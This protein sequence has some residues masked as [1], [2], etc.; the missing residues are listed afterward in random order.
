[1]TDLS[2]GAPSPNEVVDAAI[3]AFARDGYAAVKV[4]ALAKQ[5]GMTKRMIHYHFG[6][7]RGLYMRALQVALE[8]VSP[9]DEIL[10]R[11]HAV[12]VEGMRRFVDA[13]YHAFLDNPDA[14]RL[15]LRENLDPVTVDEDATVLSGAGAVALHAEGLLLAGQDAGAFRPG[16]TAVDLL[17]LISSLCFFRVGN[18]MTAQRVSRVDLGTRRNIDGMR[19]MVIDA[20]LAFVTSNI[21]YS[22]YESYLEAD[23]IPVEDP[24]LYSGDGGIV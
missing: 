1:M 22:G 7:K 5:T 3:T 21:S 24:D 8:R 16:I 13:L 17:T 19:R 9:P 15:I 18:A 12:A 14:V 10:N 6:D 4:E 2:S 23:Q 20:V 11:S